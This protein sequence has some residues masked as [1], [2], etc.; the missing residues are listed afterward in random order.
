[1]GPV[2]PP[3]TSASV[4][5]RLPALL[6][7]AL[8]LFLAAALAVAMLGVPS[9]A[10]VPAPALELRS[11][12]LPSAQF[13]TFTLNVCFC[14]TALQAEADMVK[15]FTLGDVGG[16]QEFSDLEDR[17][18]LMRLATERDWGWYMPAVGGGETTPI[19]WNRARFRLIDGHTIKTHDAV[20]D[21]TPARY[22][23][24]VRLREIATGKV[25]GVINTH[26]I[27]QASF[28][29]QLT[30]PKRIPLL[31]QHLKLLHDEIVALFTTTEHVF[32]MGDLNVNYLADRVRQNEGLPTSA[33]GDV[34]NF[35]MPL[36]GSRGAT[37]L[38]DY[39]MTVKNDS[40]LQLVTSRIEYGFN[41]DHD[42]VVFTYGTVDLFATG[43]IFNRPTGT[44]AARTEVVAR[45][46]RAVGNAEPGAR[47]RLAVTRLDDLDLM[48]ALLAAA[49][50]GVAIQVVLAEGS[51]TYAEQTLAAT[52]GSDPLLPSWVKKCVGSCLGGAGTNEANFLLVSRS[53]GATE[54]SL[55][56]NGTPQAKTGQR[57]TDA[58]MSTD[59]YVYTGYNQTFEQMAADTVDTRATRTV[60]WGPSYAAQLYPLPAGAK[61]PMLKS[62][63]RVRCKPGKTVVRVTAVAW[64]QSRGQAL[65]DQL[66]TLR[67]QGC[68]VRAVLG[69]QA[70]K[71]ISKILTAANIS[72]VR[73]PVQQNVL[74][75]KG[76]YGKTQVTRAWV[77]GP[78][79]TDN[80]LVS[81]GVTLVVND[82][83][84][85]GYLQQFYRVF[86]GK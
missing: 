12:Q 34:V 31:R 72:I 79:W 50:R 45:M 44:A 70:T 29:A 54:V 61:D 74:F 77:G 18:T 66:A 8:P 40:G 48:R 78:S 58:F 36:T 25:F 43:G 75:V 62:L 32:A 22:I 24:V 85:A 57:W 13:T 55:A 60:S 49:A 56:L 64:S 39:G 59:T 76:K 83:S 11:K 68:D 86:K 37:S 33:L 20:P 80:G 23:N 67:T 16:F 15:A 73:R 41:S 38:L 3:A 14:L 17:Q 71:K 5:R 42:A 63:K 46:V 52:L 47:V 9:G 65:A 27:A 19:V 6:Q 2:T 30:D 51:G 69:K 26:T 10:R 1:M 21:V 4:V 28:D 7:L 84:A 82:G 81:D 35:D 53:G